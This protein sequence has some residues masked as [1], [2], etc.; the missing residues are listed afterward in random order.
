M[1]TRFR[2]IDCFNKFPDPSMKFILLLLAKNTD[3]CMVDYDSFDNDPMQRC[4]GMK[5]C[6]V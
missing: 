1:F 3:V 6:K 2:V 5:N 4:S